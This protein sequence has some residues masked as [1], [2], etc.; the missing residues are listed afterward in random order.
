[1]QIFLSN[2]SYDDHGIYDNIMLLVFYYFKFPFDIDYCD[3]FITIND[4]MA[5]PY[6]F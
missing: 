1:M 3:I 5:Q 6:T 2:E 4:N